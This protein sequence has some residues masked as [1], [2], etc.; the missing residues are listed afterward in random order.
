MTDQP[1]RP[2]APPPDTLPS[3]PPPDTLPYADLPALLRDA[4]GLIAAALDVHVDETSRTDVAGLIPRWEDTARRWRDRYN[5]AAPALNRPHGAVVDVIEVLHPGE[6]PDEY[7]AITVPTEVRINGVPMLLTES[8]PVVHEIDMGTET[9]SMKRNA[10]RVT[11]TL[12]CRRVLVDARPG[13]AP[14]S[15]AGVV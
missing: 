9:G 1:T 4:E 15:A 11:M 2:S 13:S 8:G 10:T 7:P 3:D 5:A 6:D 14:G 12:L